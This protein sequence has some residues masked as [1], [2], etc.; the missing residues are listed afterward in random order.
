VNRWGVIFLAPVVFLAV[1][2]PGDMLPALGLGALGYG[3]L[4]W[5]AYKAIGKRQPPLGF[6]RAVTGQHDAL[7]LRS[8]P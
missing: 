5:L 1:V 2:A 6:A 7:H 8:P 3:V 4:L